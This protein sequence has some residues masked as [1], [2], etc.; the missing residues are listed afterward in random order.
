METLEELPFHT[1]LGRVVVGRANGDGAVEV[2][3]PTTLAAEAPEPRA[4]R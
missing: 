2:S 4:Y 1:P 3:G